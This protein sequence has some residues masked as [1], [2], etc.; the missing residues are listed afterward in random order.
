[1]QM[2]SKKRLNQ[3]AHYALVSSTAQSIGAHHGHRRESKESERSLIRGTATTTDANFIGV[4]RSTT[5]NKNLY[6]IHKD[7]M[8]RE[9]STE[10]KVKIESEETFNRMI[11]RGSVLTSVHNDSFVSNRK[12]LKV[13]PTYSSLRQFCIQRVFV[14]QRNKQMSIT[15]IQGAF[16][17]GC[18]LYTAYFLSIMLLVYGLVIWFVLILVSLSHDTDTGTPDSPINENKAWN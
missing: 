2:I 10:L 1:M 5:S 16:S 6:P 3:D 12:R 9:Y 13:K 14:A 15:Q 11:T 17:L 7:D 8:N 18:N 4:E